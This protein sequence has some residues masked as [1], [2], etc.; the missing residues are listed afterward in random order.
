M[1]N[2]SRAFGL[3][4][5][6]NLGFVA[7]ETAAA[8]WTGSAALLAD[9]G[10]NFVDGLA[11]AATFAAVWLGRLPP[12]PRLTYGLKGVASLAALANAGALLAVVVLIVLDSVSRLA[13]PQPS[14]GGWV[15]AVALASGAMNAVCAALLARGREHDLNRRG[16]F[17]HMLADLLVS[18][19]V[20]LSGLIGL[21]SGWLWV[22][23]LCSL[24]VSLFLSYAAAKL[25]AEALHMALDGVPPGLDPSEVR[26]FLARLP[27]VADVHALH[28]WPVG[29][30]ETAL[31]CHLVMP[32]GHP[33]D[34]F[35]L[36]AGASLDRKFG[37]RLAT[38]QVELGDAPAVAAIAA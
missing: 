5:V 26:D 12:T 4:A 14:A 29:A 35:I 32:G 30:T 20:A 6:I 25:F 21:A 24:G 3:A 1:T 38:L 18:L 8:Q 37:I 34:A 9:A 19:A 23:P 28:I 17:L 16:A 7:L 33:G 22:D 2:S 13:H 36:D 10:H 15:A 31:T 27:G 11:L